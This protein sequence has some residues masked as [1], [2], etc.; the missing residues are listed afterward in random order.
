MIRPS[1][2]PLAQYCGYSVTLAERYPESSAAAER[3][4]K[5]H[6]A[7]ATFVKTGAGPDRIASIFATFPAHAKC[8]AEVPVT[9]YD[10][11]T[12]DIVSAGTLDIVL[13]HVDGSLTIIDHKTGMPDKVDRPDDNLQLAVYG[14]GTALERGA[15]KFRVGISFPDNPPLQLSRW[16]CDGDDYWNMLARIKAAAT[17]PRNEPKSGDHCNRC[18]SRKHCHAWALVAS[19]G[20]GELAR[21]TP[22]DLVDDEKIASVL[23]GITALEERIK[24]MKAHIQD[25]ARM[26]PII[27]GGKEYGPALSNGRRSVSID[28]LEQAGLL[29][30]AE[31]AGAINPGRPYEVFRWRNASG[32]G[33]KAKG[34]A[35]EWLAPVP[36]IVAKKARAKK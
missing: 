26:A 14:L 24:I 23:L 33:E 6:E 1:R 30:A 25:R 8:E 15:P 28:S 21:T 12:G 3:G 5:Y 29:E 16:F 11:E 2:L 4:A 35:S 20:E 13:T 9:L 7:F 10:P 17:Q 36:E 31:K 22:G 34:G 19:T 18:Y 32:R 27:A